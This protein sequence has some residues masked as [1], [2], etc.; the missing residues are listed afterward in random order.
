MLLYLLTTVFAPKQATAGPHPVDELAG[1]T[2]SVVESSERKA[3]KIQDGIR[4][5]AETHQP[6][7]HSEQLQDARN[8]AAFAACQCAARLP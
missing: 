1:S 3:L 7:K 4:V 5:N 8:I 6:N 2:E